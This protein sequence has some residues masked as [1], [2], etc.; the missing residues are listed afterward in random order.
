MEDNAHPSPSDDVEG[1][2]GRVLVVDDQQ[3]IRRWVRTVLE[4]AGHE[5]VTAESVKTGVEALHEPFDVGVFDVDLPD[6]KGFEL[7]EFARQHSGAP[8]PIVM[9]TGNPNDENV[10]GG[11]T[12]GITEFLFKPFEKG[13]LREAVERALATKT[14]WEKRLAAVRADGAEPSPDSGWPT[15]GLE[16]SEANRLVSQL[17]ESAGLTDRERETLQL[18]LLGLQNSDIAESLKIS[19]NTVKYHV[20]NVLTKV[21][22][23]S[24]TELF[25]SLLSRSDD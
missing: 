12:R 2:R 19:A 24:R 1:R 7:V 6:G 5:V 8:L 14:R 22:M 11:V 18:M 21:G 13:E 25:R 20:R 17:T 15:D 16:T 23:E 4:N 10:E 9:I 3:P